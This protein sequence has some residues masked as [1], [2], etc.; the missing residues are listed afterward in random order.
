MARQKG[1]LG[2]ACWLRFRFRTRSFLSA[3]TGVGIGARREV[4]DE[5][6]VRAMSG[7][8]G[9]NR[10]LIMDEKRAVWGGWRG[11]LEVGEVDAAA[12]FKFFVFDLE[13]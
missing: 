10:K 13:C 4:G 11:G 3:V 5:P 7:E 6:G 8:T 9:G 12:L 2:V 1:E